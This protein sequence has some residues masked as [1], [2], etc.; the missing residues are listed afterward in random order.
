[1]KEEVNNLRKSQHLNVVGY[2]D[3]FISG[4]SVF[5]AME[6]CNQGS[7]EDYLKEKGEKI[8]W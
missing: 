5:I 7:L 6:F 3:C 1:M 4:T 2:I 8:P